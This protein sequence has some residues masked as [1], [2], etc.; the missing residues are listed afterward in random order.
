MAL[1]IW[2]VRLCTEQTGL[3][4][5]SVY[6]LNFLL[7]FFKILIKYIVFCISNKTQVLYHI[8]ANIDTQ[9]NPCIHLLCW[10]HTYNKTKW[11]CFKTSKCLKTNFIWWL[12][13]ETFDFPQDIFWEWSK[14]EQQQ[15]FASKM[16]KDVGLLQQQHICMQVH[17]LPVLIKDFQ[18]DSFLFGFART[19]RLRVF[20][21]RGTAGCIA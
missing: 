15:Q 5:K 7:E 11:Q 13:N 9:S 8:S 16:H 1:N 18:N 12:R 6:F 4:R 14:K 19:M 17:T 3:C 2:E 10:S 21:F 20:R